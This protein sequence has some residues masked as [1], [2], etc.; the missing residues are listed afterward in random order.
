MKPFRFRLERLKK[1]RSSQE[2]A[3]RNVFA[4]ALDGLAPD[5]CNGVWKPPATKVSADQPD[6]AASIDST[7]ISPM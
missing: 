5:R 2:R 4:G 6:A 7:G 3:A 1:V